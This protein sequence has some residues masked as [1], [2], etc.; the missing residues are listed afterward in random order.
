MQTFP[1]TYEKATSFISNMVQLNNIEEIDPNFYID[2]DEILFKYDEEA[3][4]C[5]SIEIYQFFI[6]DC[7][8]ELV[9]HIKELFP[10][11]IFA[12]SNRLDSWILCVDHYGTLWSGVYC[13]TTD[14]F[15]KSEEAL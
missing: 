9:E 8:T 5:K 14:D 15:F 7:S 3:G 4:Y 12:F 10:S 13:E 1:S 11:L 6:T 2:N